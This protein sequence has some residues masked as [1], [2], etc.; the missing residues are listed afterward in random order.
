MLTRTGPTVTSKRRAATWAGACTVAMATAAVA[1]AQL[2]PSPPAPPA[3]TQPSATQPA[4][5]V[6][7]T[8]IRQLGADEDADRRVAA[9][10]LVDLGATVVDALRAAA[11][12]DADLDVR[13]GSAAVLAQIRD[14]DA[15]GPTLITLH[16]QG[17][18]V[19]AV[20]KQI[21]DQAHADISD[22]IPNFGG[23]ARSALTLDADRKP[24]WD[25][26]A[27]VCGQLNVC[28]QLSDAPNHATVRLFPTN[29]NWMTHGP[30]QVVGPFWVGVA[31]LDR[32]S[33]V[34]LSGPPLS[35]DT[36]MARLIV[37]P[38]PKLVV[39]Q[40]SPLTVREAVDDAGNSLVPTAVGP[41]GRLAARSAARMPARTVEARLRYPAGHPGHRI[42]TLAGDL[43][44]TLAQ[45]AQRFE[46]D[47]VMGRPT[48]TR[49]LPGVKVRVAVARQGISGYSVTVEC[50]RDGLADP[51]WYAMT[52]RIYDLT[53]EDGAGHVLASPAWWNVDAGNSDTVFKATGMFSRQAAGNLLVNRLPAA[54]AGNPPVA[55]A[56]V[57]IIGE[58]QRVVWNVAAR[59]KVVTL[60][61]AFHDLPM[62]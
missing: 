3:A 55:A 1:V 4:D 15:N 58:P 59:F 8:L 12:H 43:T 52:N 56:A 46:A 19:P 53:V 10:Q 23:A 38:E 24:Y 16:V 13:T 20:L 14:R 62:P 31:G 60:P 47:D 9:Q 36:F 32:Q 41:A 48:V 39:T 6:V 26:L 30:H 44:V 7:A 61:V 35:Y 54:V 45:G 42:V 34:D 37:F 21:G 49:P 33:W 22:V 11:D 29:R 18:D 40:V 2:A 17:G 5:A 50:G 27:D 25:V 51:Q 57:P 28:P